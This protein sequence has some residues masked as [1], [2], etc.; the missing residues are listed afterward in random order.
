MNLTPP[1]DPSTSSGHRKLRAPRPICS[2]DDFVPVTNFLYGRQL[3]QPLRPYWNTGQ[4]RLALYLTM[5][6]GRKSNHQLWKDDTGQ[7]QAY[8]YLSEKTPIYSTP[9]VREWRLLLHPEQRT[10][11][12]IS[13]LIEHAEARLEARLSG[14]PIRT[15]AYDSD[16]A[17]TALLQHHGYVKQHAL[18]VYM[19]R[20][21]TDPIP[22]PVVPDGFMVRAFAGQHELLSR[23]KLTDSA[24]GGSEGPSDRAINEVNNMIRFCQAI[25]A[26]DFIAT[27]PDGLI[28]SSSIASCD[29]VTKLGE[30]D[31][32]GTHRLYWQRGLAKALLLTGLHW[33]RG[34]G[35]QRAVIRTNV[36]NIAA[37]RAYQSVGYQIVDRLF[38]YEKQS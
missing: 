29:P 1:F 16:R 22:L 9:E 10:N 2:V 25:Q 35:M 7:I 37:Q 36:D 8:M 11:P 21:L 38:L 23:A 18:E 13:G 30:F 17:W 20:S 26:I 31:P 12:L 15:V 19:T 27:T 33:M 5:F 4:A 24:F 14:D 3:W 34:A 6:E 32:V 28:V